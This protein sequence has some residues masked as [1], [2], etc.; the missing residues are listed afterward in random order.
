MQPS[1]SYVA[2]ELASGYGQ[3]SS[4]EVTP[5]CDI[6]SFGLVAY[7]A[8]VKHKLLRVKDEL[9]DYKNQVAGIAQSDLSAVSPNFQ[10]EGLG[11][12]L[13]SLAP[14]LLSS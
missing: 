3:D 11:G 10:C 13:S 4:T 9:M 2:P 5:T 1:L 8:I 12:G 6:F 7:E 14:I